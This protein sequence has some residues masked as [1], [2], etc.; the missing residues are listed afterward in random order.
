MTLPTLSYPPTSQNQR[1]A[2]YTG[3]GDEQPHIY[4]TTVSWLSEGE[5]NDL[6]NAAYR[7]IFHEQHMLKS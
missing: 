5:K 2:S 3:A 1:V 4:D 7:Q 6:I